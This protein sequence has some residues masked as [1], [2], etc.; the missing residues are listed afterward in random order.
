MFPNWVGQFPL[1]EEYR[2]FVQSQGYDPLRGHLQQLVR[3][4]DAA[5]RKTQPDAAEPDRKTLE[6]PGDPA[7]SHQTPS[8]RG[9]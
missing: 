1:A 3:R 8:A 2:V 9:L 4:L 5:D 7:R 6:A